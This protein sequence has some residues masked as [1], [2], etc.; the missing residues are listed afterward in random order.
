MTDDLYYRKLESTST[1]DLVDML[2][3]KDRRIEELEQE[4]A[5]L[6]EQCSILADCNTCYSTCKTENVEMRK[7]LIKAKEIIQKL[8]DIV[9]GRG[10]AWELIEQA[11]EWL[12]ERYLKD[13]GVRNPCKKAFLAGLKA[14]K[15]MAEA[16]LATIAYMQGAERYKTKWH[17]LRVNP[18]DLPKHSGL[19]CVQCGE[20]REYVKEERS[21]FTVHFEPCMNRTEDTYLWCEIP[22]YK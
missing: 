11:E 6:K 15:A 5:E 10:D 9:C 8:N 19:Y 21:W 22:K 1:S 7:Q 18:N 14:G 17:D 13:M 12:D 2:R 3:E 16:D 20:V 4:N